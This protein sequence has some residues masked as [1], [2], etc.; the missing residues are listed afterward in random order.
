M[1][2]E[3]AHTGA[4]MGALVGDSLTQEGFKTPPT[5]MLWA[6]LNRAAH[7]VQ[8]QIVS[9][10]EHMLSFTYDYASVPAGTA[11]LDLP[12]STGLGGSEVRFRR[13]LQLLRTDLDPPVP[14]AVVDARQLQEE[15]HLNARGSEAV[16]LE[17]MTIRFLATGGAPAAWTLRL[18]YVGALPEFSGTN[19]ST[20]F[21]LIPPEW[22]EA[23]IDLAVSFLIPASK[24]EAKRA[25][26]IRAFA[27]M[28]RLSAVVVRRVH[29]GGSH[30]RRV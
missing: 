11:S 20:A 10:N 29:D 3:T 28:K 15:P 21:N 19:Q 5:E 27:A 1:G 4:E 22:S 24:T 17:N 7:R 8:D 12:G 30:I 13:L 26:E 18:R 6:M 25:Y 16:T 14:V 23:L 9:V 2:Y